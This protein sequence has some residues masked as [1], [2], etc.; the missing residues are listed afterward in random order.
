M[1]AVTAPLAGATTL[2]YHK[3][4]LRNYTP[5]ACHGDLGGCLG[6][7]ASTASGLVLLGAQDHIAAARRTRRAAHSGKGARRRSRRHQITR[8]FAHVEAAPEARADNR[9]VRLQRKGDAEISSEF[10]GSVL[11]GFAPST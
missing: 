5:T 11:D 8:H 6:G 3:V 9:L 1:K 7:P 2:L 4:I 10:V